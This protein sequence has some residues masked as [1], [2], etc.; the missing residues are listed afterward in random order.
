MYF[1]ANSRLILFPIPMHQEESLTDMDIKNNIT[2]MMLSHP[3]LLLFLLF[4]PSLDQAIYLTSCAKAIVFLS[5]EPAIT[6]I[7]LML[8]MFYLQH[9][10]CEK[11]SFLALYLIS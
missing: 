3:E 10:I 9:A 11:W 1:K 6:P 7:L 4:L 8:T 5:E 2:T